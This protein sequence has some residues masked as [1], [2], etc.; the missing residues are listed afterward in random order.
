MSACKQQVSE[1]RMSVQL[2]PEAHLDERVVAAPRRLE[3]MAPVL[4]GAARYLLT[5]AGERLAAPHESA[6]PPPEGGMAG[7]QPTGGQAM[8]EF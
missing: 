4:R 6:A 1:V 3:D 5:G 8:E 7:A 2:Q